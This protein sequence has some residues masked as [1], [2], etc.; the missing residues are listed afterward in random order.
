LFIQIGA[1]RRPKEPQGRSENGSQ[2]NLSSG[3]ANT[4]SVLRVAQTRSLFYTAW[5]MNRHSPLL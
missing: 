5:A 2:G 4:G 1:H 3:N